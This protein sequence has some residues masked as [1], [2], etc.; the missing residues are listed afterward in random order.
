MGHV[1]EGDAWQ[2]MVSPVF[3]GFLLRQRP[4]SSIIS[5]DCWAPLS[6]EKEYFD[7]SNSQTLVC[8]M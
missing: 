7:V 2:Q 6:Y 3:L 8:F 1:I 5:I 4:L